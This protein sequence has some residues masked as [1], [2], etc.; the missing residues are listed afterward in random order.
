MVYNELLLLLF[1]VRAWQLRLSSAF[2]GYCSSACCEHHYH[3]IDQS[4]FLL[5]CEAYSII[6]LVLYLETF[7]EH[8]PSSPACNE[9]WVSA[10]QHL[11]PR[12]AYI[13]HSYTLKM[14]QTNLELN[15]CCLL[16]SHLSSSISNYRTV[17]AQPKP[18]KIRFASF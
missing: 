12:I 9:L 13:I 2:Y 7:A 16:S 18:C 5:P 15:F 4:T 11:M 6:S 14:S 8:Y 3:N 10:L 1:Y 17:W